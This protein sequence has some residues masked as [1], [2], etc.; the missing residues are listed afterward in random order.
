MANIGRRGFMGF[1]LA[2]GV[3]GCSRVAATPA[4]IEALRGGGHVIYFRHAATDWQ[5][6]DQHTWP[7]ER[8]RLL[9]EQGIADSRR[10][11]ARFAALGIPVDEV[12]AS[13]F[14]RCVEMGELAFGRATVEPRLLPPEGAGGPPGRTAWLRTLLAT[15]RPGQGNLVLIAH[16]SNM[17]FG[18]GVVLAEGEAAII[19]PGGDE[20]HI[21][22]GQLM[23]RDW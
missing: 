8:Q 7:R 20:G 10:I 14:A 11:G 2:A 18:V 22:T 19:R 17:M 23:P 5:G 13:P 9:S 21:V 4:A 1:L 15:P 12:L 3:A 6:S 16:S